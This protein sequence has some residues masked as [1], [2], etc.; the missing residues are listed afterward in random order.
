MNVPDPVETPTV[1]VEVAAAIIGVSKYTA[2]ESA[3][4][5][6]ATGEG[7]PVVRVTERRLLVP[8]AELRR[9]LGLDHPNA[10]EPG[11]AHALAPGSVVDISASRATR[12][13]T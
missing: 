9:W 11:T 10:K 13:A 2:Y 4:R 6:Q 7:L 3:K 1:T 12:T 8:V 5:Y